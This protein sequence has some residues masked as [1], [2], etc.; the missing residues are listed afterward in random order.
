[1]A[2]D[3][4]LSLDEI[5]TGGRFDLSN[6]YDHPCD[7]DDEKDLGT[8]V[9]IDQNLQSCNYI[10]PNQ[11]LDKIFSTLKSELKNNH[12]SSYFHINCR[13]LSS[14]WDK[15][16]DLIC[17]MTSETLSLDYIGLSE[18]FSCDNDKRI[19]LPGYHKLIT[20]CREGKS[21]RRGGVGIFINESIDYKVREDLTVFIPNVYESLFVET[22]PKGGKHTI[23]GVIYRPNTFPLADVDVFTTTLLDVLDQINAENKKC[24]VMG[25]MNIDMLKYGTNETTN[26]YVDGIIS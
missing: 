23:I 5:R 12:I 8:T 24:V 4:R 26:I 14:N 22:L 2:G 20:R 1:M 9:H 19:A 25:D 6:M 18:V 10:E 16:H 13:G 11:L 3:N 7:R 15:F 17:D 21:G